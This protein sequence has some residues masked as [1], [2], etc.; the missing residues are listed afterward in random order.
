MKRSNILYLLVIFLLVAAPA[1][2]SSLYYAMSDTAQPPLGI[3]WEA[4]NHYDGER[5]T[6]DAT[7]HWG[8]NAQI[9]ISKYN[10]TNALREA[11]R[12]RG[13]EINLEILTVPNNDA[14]TITYNIGSTQLGPVPLQQAASQISPAIAAYRQLTN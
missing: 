11:F 7:L 12:T 13:M 6:I 4:E 9:N 8:A 14:I 10:Y 1:G 2:I 3:T 5:V